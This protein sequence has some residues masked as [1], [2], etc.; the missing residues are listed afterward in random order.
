MISVIVPTYNEE[1]NIVKCLAH[2]QEQTLWKDQYE[3]IVVD[4]H[5]TDL[6]VNKAKAFISNKVISQK[7]KGVGGARNDGIAIAKGDIVAMTDADCYVPDDWLENI[8]NFFNKDPSTVCVYGPVKTTQHDNK[9]K[10][11][12]YLWVSNTAAYI[13]H[14]FGLVYWTVGANCAFRKKP[15][16]EIGGYKEYS[17]GDDIEIGIRLRKKG[18]IMYSRKMYVYFSMRRYEMFGIIKTLCIWLCGVSKDVFGMNIGKKVD[19]Y[20]RVDYTKVKK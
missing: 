7:S 5:S 9:L 4:G 17:A 10:Y 3:I 11:K 1:K 20:N 14:V 18:K 19:S 6:T 13:S 8:Q 2:L 15:F 12:F 16:L